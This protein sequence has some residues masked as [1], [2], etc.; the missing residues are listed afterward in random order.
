MRPTPRPP[1]LRPGCPLLP[2][3]GG[4][5]GCGPPPRQL[6]RWERQSQPLAVGRYARAAFQKLL[7][8]VE[9][10]VAV[11]GDATLAQE[12]ALLRKLAGLEGGSSQEAAA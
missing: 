2:P 1:R 10:E 5:A 7:L 11:L 9:G 8:F 12:V 6:G 3:A 4:A